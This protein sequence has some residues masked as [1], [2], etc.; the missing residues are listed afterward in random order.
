MSNN[1]AKMLEYRNA[2]YQGIFASR[3]AVAKGGE[4]ARPPLANTREENVFWYKGFHEGLQSRK[5]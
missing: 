3:K 4:L 2:Y 5:A 1:W